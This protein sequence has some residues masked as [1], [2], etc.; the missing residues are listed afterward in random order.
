MITRRSLLA[1]ALAAGAAVPLGAGPALA[2]PPR[3]RLPRPTG[4]HPI[5]VVPWHLTGA[6]ELMA[7]VWYPARVSHRRRAEWLLPAPTRALLG[8]VGFDPDVALAPVTAG[9]L[10]APVAAGRHPVILYSHGNDGHRGEATTMVQELVSHGYVVV[11]VDH[12]GDAYTEFPGGRLSVPDEGSFTP[13]DSAHDMVLV[14]DRVEDLALGPVSAAALDL[15]RVGIAGWSKGGT[16]AALVMNIDRRVRAGLSLDGPMESQPRPTAID[17]PFMLMT[18]E[19][20][21]G[22]EPV[23]TLWSL[24]RGWRLTMHACGAAH[25]SYCDNPTLLTQL[26]RITGMSDEELI[27]WIGTLDA[28]HATRIQQAYPLAF[29]DLHLRGRRQRLLERPSPAFPEV[30]FI[31]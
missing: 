4:P 5:G 18:A 9:R 7:S 13:W 11:T 1:A 25:G 23:D 26:A 21:R 2:A 19:S 22:T 27:E 20:V 16:S 8:A 14:L 29:F 28:G 30:R 31:R 15:R 12:T 6:R 24:L 17:R 3:L 10:G